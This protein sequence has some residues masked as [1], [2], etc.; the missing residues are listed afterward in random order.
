[1]VCT[2]KYIAAAVEMCAI[3]FAMGMRS[4]LLL[5][6]EAHLYTRLRALA[7][8]RSLDPAHLITGRRGED[9]AYFHL[10]SL[11][12]TVV[13]RRWRSPRLNGDLDLV[14]WDGATL[15]VFEVKTRTT[16]DPA[17][18]FAPAETAVDGPKQDQLRLMAS[19]YLRQIPEHHRAA[20][21]LRFD[22]LSVY[23]LPAETQFHHIRDAFPA[24]APP[25]RAW[26]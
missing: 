21:A 1:L 7:D 20:V 13:A 4:N 9:A 3:L 22:V 24:T 6:S 12:Y 16:A 10:R 5:R 26:R 19:A 2:L 23:L 14:A 17:T 8:R 18:M 11:G 15:V 25:R